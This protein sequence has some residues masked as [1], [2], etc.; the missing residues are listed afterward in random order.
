M[1][2]FIDYL[3][4]LETGIGEDR[5][6]AYASHTPDYTI[7]SGGTGPKQIL[8]AL[9][10]E[11]KVDPRK[12]NV[13]I[14]MYDDGKST[15][16]CREMFDILGPSDL[17]KNH[18]TLSDIIY[19]E[20]GLVDSYLKENQ[21]TME[22][23]DLE[24]YTYRTILGL[25]M[26]YDLVR[27]IL[28]HRISFPQQEPESR[29]KADRCRL[30]RYTSY[31][32]I[33]SHIDKCF[34]DAKARLANYNQSCVDEGRINEVIHWS[35]IAFPA[36]PNPSNDCMRFNE[37]YLSTLYIFFK[38]MVV[39]FLTETPSKIMLN[40][41]SLE[42]YSGHINNSKEPYEITKD[43]LIEL[44]SRPYFELEDF[45]IGN[46]IYAA[47]MNTA[48]NR[49]DQKNQ[50]P[51]AVTAFFMSLEVFKIPNM[52]SVVSEPSLYLVGFHLDSENRSFYLK[53]EAAIVDFGKDGT[54]PVDHYISGVYLNK[55][56]HTDE[57]ECKF[58]FPSVG[59]GLNGIS[60]ED[61][62]Y[63]S[64]LL[65]K[66]ATTKHFIVSSGTFWS[67]LYPTFMHSDF[68]E[69]LE[70]TTGDITFVLNRQPDYDMPYINSDEYLELL[71]SSVVNDDTEKKINVIVD[72]SSNY[73]GQLKKADVPNEHK[74]V[75]FIKRALAPS[76]KDANQK[77]HDYKK[78]AKVF[79][80]L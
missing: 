65:Y 31:R 66:I 75:N 29:T 28:S 50:Y 11:N 63:K 36:Q 6:T 72:S 52:V 69:L 7:F 25:K 62:K 17:R 14:N 56:F 16:K 44:K 1:T 49:V 58:Y 19:G 4:L 27:S 23:S 79:E 33:M 70:N 53:D 35:D 64:D 8:K 3:C 77:M 20:G 40:D 21:I 67:S 54:V 42:S 39:S 73:I 61:N 43:Q 10:L 78:L 80:T 34:I 59:D 32:T 71:M 47:L 22:S 30:T 76:A 2:N 15:G 51:A 5:E 12:V 74:N 57:G 45:S 68:K 55:K 26:R 24:S 9:L 60:D 38:D 13:T 46:I 41:F 18:E 37:Y 48:K